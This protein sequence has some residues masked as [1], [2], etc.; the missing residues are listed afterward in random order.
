MPVIRYRSCTLTRV[1]RDPVAYVTD[2]GKAAAVES[3][4]ILH[5]DRAYDALRD[6]AARAH[7]NTKPL[8]H[9]VISWPSDEHPT[10]PDALTYAKEV[11]KLVG[12]YANQWIAAAHADAPH[13]H[14][15]I[16][17]SR[18]NPISFDLTSSKQIYERIFEH[19]NT[20][21]VKHGY[22]PIDVPFK[23]RPRNSGDAEVWNGRRSFYAFLEQ[24]LREAAPR[25][26]D[27][28]DR[29]LARAGVVR[30]RAHGGWRFEDR[31]HPEKVWRARAS[32]LG[33]RP[34]RLLSWGE[35]PPTGEPDP[36]AD[37]Y[38]HFLERDESLTPFA[39]SHPRLRDYFAA[40]RDGDSVGR[41]GYFLRRGHTRLTPPLVTRPLTER[42]H[43][44]ATTPSA[45]NRDPV[46]DEELAAA[47]ERERAGATAQA[48][49]GLLVGPPVGQ[50][51]KNPT[52]STLDDLLRAWERQLTDVYELPKERVARIVAAE[53]AKRAARATLAESWI[54]LET[55]LNRDRKPFL[56]QVT[57]Y[58]RALRREALIQAL[59]QAAGE[60]PPPSLAEYTNLGPVAGNA[61]DRTTAARLLGTTPDLVDRDAPPDREALLSRLWVERLE[62]EEEQPQ[63]GGWLY[64]LDPPGTSQDVA[65][66]RTF[67]E[68]ADG[69]YH[70]GDHKTYDTDVVDAALLLMARRYGGRVSVYASGQQLD[71]VLGRAA[72]LGIEVTNENLR[73]RYSKILDAARH[74]ASTA[75]VSRRQTPLSSADSDAYAARVAIGADALPLHEA[76]Q[77]HQGALSGVVRDAFL[78][79]GCRYVQLDT[80]SGVVFGQLTTNKDTDI[81]PGDSIHCELNDGMAVLT[82]HEHVERR[83]P[84]AQEPDR[85][86]RQRKRHR[87]RGGLTR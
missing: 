75:E 63:S 15:H 80:P 1:G 46:V 62:A 68:E 81:V 79:N 45:P 69:R 17:A 64:H 9:L 51:R 37:T 3:R 43:T 74:D 14:V 59:E 49:S 76:M 86:Q 11:L 19:T 41:I 78:H 33:L 36:D 65:E 66:K 2:G 7:G 29:I 25:S 77:V 70:L 32:Q 18:I 67:I 56:A 16:I 39:L 52:F 27:D 57:K 85:E 61:L 30:V 5:P 47:Q 71:Q 6:V 72:A 44:V 24:R 48:A 20:L 53:R 10:I 54:G 35:P 83:E 38:W 8:A 55:D 28:L 23:M 13:K 87:D 26:W 34:E 21:A 60:Y 50:T 82:H 22:R 84:R 42:E 12:L 58:G 73:D 40:Q 4:R 31:S